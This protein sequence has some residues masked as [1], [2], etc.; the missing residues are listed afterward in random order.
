[1][2]IYTIN[3]FGNLIYTLC[4]SEFI[5][6]LSKKNDYYSYYLNLQLKQVRS[7]AKIIPADI[8]QLK[9]CIRKTGMLNSDALILNLETSLT[10]YFMSTVSM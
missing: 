3:F 10:N 9:V 4:K 5:N 7:L 2:C 8:Y 1:M 6:K